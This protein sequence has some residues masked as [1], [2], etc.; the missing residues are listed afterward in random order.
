[1]KEAED[2]EQ[3]ARRLHERRRGLRLVPVRERE[4]LLPDSTIKD[5]IEEM[6]GRD[7][8]KRV[9]LPPDDG[10]EVA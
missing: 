2:N 6:M 7:K 9:R 1:M 10:P 5:L 8:V 4:S 3:D